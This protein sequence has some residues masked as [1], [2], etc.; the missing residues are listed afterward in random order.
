MPIPVSAAARRFPSLG[1]LVHVPVP[2]HVHEGRERVR[3]R[4]RPRGTTAPARETPGGANRPLLPGACTRPC[5]S[6]R[7]R[8]AGATAEYRPE[9]GA[10]ATAPRHRPAPVRWLVSASES[11]SESQSTLMATA[12]PIPIPIPAAEATT[13]GVCP[14]GYVAAARFDGFPPCFTP[15][16]RPHVAHRQPLR[17]VSPPARQSRP[18]HIGTEPFFSL[19]RAATRPTMPAMLALAATVSMSEMEGVH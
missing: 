2:V 11:A 13:Q 19:E 15:P 7:S 5:P 10:R 6:R 16:P 14:W 9:G 17:P 18:R 4:V 8:W 3:E 1:L 12:V